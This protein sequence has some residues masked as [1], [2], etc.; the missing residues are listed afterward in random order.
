MRPT[1]VIV[2]QNGKVAAVTE[3]DSVTAAGLM[4]VAAGKD[5]GFKPAPEVTEASGASLPNGDQPLFEVSVSKAKPDAKESQV[6]HPPTG[7]DFLGVD[8]DTL[9]TDVFKPFENRYALKDPLPEGRYN[10]RVNFANVPQTAITTV[11]RQSVLSALH[12]KVESKTV[13]KPAYILRATDASRKLLSPS[14]STH[15]VKRGSWHGMYVLMN[16]TMDD[17]AFVLATGLETPVLNETGIDGRYD[18][19]LKVAGDD[20]SSLNAALKGKLGLELVPGKQEMPITVLE[21]S[22]QTE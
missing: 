4:A 19:R 17:L 10:L 1:T 16:G 9:M 8:A 11:V 14:A 15:A 12:L 21:V 3:I 20:L 7:T 2:D 13:S 18:A 22:R 6:N 5:A